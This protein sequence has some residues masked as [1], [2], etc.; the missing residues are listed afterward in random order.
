MTPGRLASTALLP[1]W[2]LEALASVP[3]TTTFT[4][5]ALVVISVLGAL[6]VLRLQLRREDDSPPSL[7]GA[8]LAIACGGFGTFIS[9]IAYF[10]GPQVGMLAVFADMLPYAI[11][12]LVFGVFSLFSAAR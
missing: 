10:A 2:P 9:L 12:L 7:F 4:H 5:N 3:G 8:L 6:I 1:A 11:G